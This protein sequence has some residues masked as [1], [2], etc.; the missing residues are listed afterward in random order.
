MDTRDLF[1][2]EILQDAIGKSCAKSEFSIK[3]LV[4]LSFLGGGYVG[5]GYLALPTRHQRP[6]LP[7]GT[8]GR[9]IGRICVPY[10]T[11]LYLNRRR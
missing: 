11:D 4:I 7:N 2:H 5:F 10:R 3:M 9:S 1:P 6:F 8:S